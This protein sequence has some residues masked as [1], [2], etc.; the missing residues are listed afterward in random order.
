[1]TVPNQVLWNYRVG[2]K[3]LDRKEHQR[4]TEEESAYVLFVTGSYYDQKDGDNWLRFINTPNKPKEKANV[5]IDPNGDFVFTGKSDYVGFLWASYG[6]A[7]WEAEQF[8]DTGILEVSVPDKLHPYIESILEK[9][10]KWEQVFLKQDDKDKEPEMDKKRRLRHLHGGDYQNQ[11][12]K[13][14]GKTFNEKLSTC[15]SEWYATQNTVLDSIAGGEDQELHKD[16]AIE[17]FQEL[18][19]WPVHSAII[20]GQYGAQLLVQPPGETEPKIHDIGKYTMLMFYGRLLHAG[21]GMEEK[22]CKYIGKDG[23]KHHRR[24]HT[25]VGPEALLGKMEAEKREGIPREQRFFNRT[26][27][28]DKSTSLSWYPEPS[29]SK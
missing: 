10:G 3:V 14:V 12:F 6:D 9:D 17:M 25:Y 16:I 24:I 15:V 8:N 22:H 28:S 13:W 20:T 29:A 18:D 7:Y 26:D 11:I 1:M 21:K 2:A 5:R 4:L 19:E 27:L 23:A